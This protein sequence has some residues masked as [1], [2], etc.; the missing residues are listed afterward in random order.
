MNGKGGL[1]RMGMLTT[2]VLLV[3][4]FIH[5]AQKSPFK[6][7][8]DT[9]ATPPEEKVF[10]GELHYSRVPVEY[11]EHRILMVKALGLNTLSVYIMWNFHE[12]EDG[13]FDFQT[14][15]RNLTLFLELATKHH[16][17]VLIRPGPYV[18]AE[19]DMGGFPPRLM[20]I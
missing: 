19:W 2:L 11:W 6:P 3:S 14:G 8:A 10:A 20:A 17:M 15:R 1:V 4:G 5:Q 13:S 9:T 7:F 16:M 12:R 18:C